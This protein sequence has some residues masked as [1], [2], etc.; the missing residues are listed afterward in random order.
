MIAEL[1]GRTTV[2]FSTHILGDVERVCDHVAVLDHG[3]VRAAG[4]LDEVM[5]RH[6]GA[7]RVVVQL[8]GD[9]DV[10]A[11]RLAGETWVDAI[12]RSEPPASDGGDV[13]EIAT[14]DIPRA[15]RRVPA[16]VAELD[17]GLVRFEVRQPSLEDVFVSL[18]APDPG[19]AERRPAES[20]G[21]AR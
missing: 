11:E 10:L 15:R 21:N 17:A 19:R 3:L 5:S 9:A 20:E 16:L 4:P 2:L 6:A 7:Q 13:I 1:R 8:D 12:T 18:V 14:D